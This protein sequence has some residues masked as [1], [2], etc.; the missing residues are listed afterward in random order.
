VIRQVGLDNIGVV[1]TEGKLSG[2]KSLKVDTGA[3][4]L[5]DALRARNLKVVTNYQI[6]HVMRVE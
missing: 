4:N 5:D 1:A 2:L 3:P 6:E